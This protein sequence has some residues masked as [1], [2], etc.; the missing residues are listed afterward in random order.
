MIE[1]DGRGRPAALLEAAAVG[2]AGAVLA[3]SC[4]SILGWTPMVVAGAGVAAGLN[5][6]VSGARGIYRWRRPQ[7]WV[8]WVLDSTWG[9]VGVAGGVLVHLAN[10]FHP[11]P[12]YVSGMSRRSNRHVYEGGF[13][14]RSGFAIAVGNVVSAGGGTTGL[15]GESPRVTRRRRLVDVHEGAHVFQNRL[16]GPLYVVGY[17]AWLVLAGAAG[18][19]IGPALDRRNWRS[20]VETLAYYDNPFEYWAYRRDGYWPPA[21]A[22]PRF[23]WRTRS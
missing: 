10:A 21:G 23:V 1:P 8:C 22:H 19:L 18:L 17:G 13:T 12:G 4:L 9:L 11:S 16:F 20:V 7:G 15:R 14:F 2:L 5:G 6:A 3:W